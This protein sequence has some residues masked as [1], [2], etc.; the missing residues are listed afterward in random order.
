MPYR[1]QLM[2]AEAAGSRPERSKM[3]PAVRKDASVP[4]VLVVDDD[5]DIRDILSYGITASGCRCLTADSA[6]SALDVLR[7]APV[8]VVISDVQMEG[9]SGLDLCRRI[10]DRY[11]ADVIIITGLI[12]NFA[13]EEILAQGASDFIEKPIR[14]AEIVARLKRVLNERQIRGQ[15]T[16]SAEKLRRNAGRFKKAMEGFVQAIA[17]AVEM[18]DPYTS[19]HQN[20]VSDLACAI[21]REMGLSRDRIYGLRMASVIHDLGKITI[22]GEI[23]CKPGRLS[24]PEYEMI[25]THVQ[26]GYDI[27]RK[28]DFPWPLADIVIQH[29]E[30]LDGSGYPFGLSG[31]EIL[32]EARILAVSDVYE[33]IGSHRP[34][35]PSL[36][37]KKAMDELIGGSGSLYD[38]PV[39]EACRHLIEE[40]RFRFKGTKGASVFVTT[41]MQSL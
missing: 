41:Q 4:L 31:E 14:L 39:V 22:P 23:L 10:K 35:R 7:T 29:H 6:E 40:N 15:L 27:L 17:L 16:D 19:G 26:S 5:D 3:E 37:L 20:R 9:M 21:A 2:H 25:K 12:N 30:R 32:L 33:T 28:I 13:Y 36:G 8:E 18:R 38:P 11:D 1:L 34:Y 24:G